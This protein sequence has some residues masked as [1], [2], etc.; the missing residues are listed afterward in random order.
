MQGRGA[1]ECLIYAAS[2]A[3]CATRSRQEWE[4]CRSEVM[5]FELWKGLPGL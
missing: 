2:G 1:L 5:V 4:E 3:V